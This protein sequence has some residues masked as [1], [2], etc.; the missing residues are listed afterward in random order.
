[1]GI[2][3]ALLCL[4]LPPLAVL[5]KGCGTILLVSAPPHPTGSAGGLDE[6]LPMPSAT[7]PTCRALLVVGCGGPPGQRHGRSA[8]ARAAPSGGLAQ[9]TGSARGS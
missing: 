7:E 6:V 2:G 1:M 3:R 9:A 4:L 8:V 5:D